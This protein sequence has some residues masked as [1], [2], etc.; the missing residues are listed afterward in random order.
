MSSCTESVGDS[1]KAREAALR[2]L[3]Q[4]CKSVP[5]KKPCPEEHRVGSC[6]TLDGFVEH[7]YATGARPYTT[8]E[9]KAECENRD[10]RWLG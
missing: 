7:Y 5:Q 8:E 4:F 1:P 9:A 2:A 3:G 6:R 10:G